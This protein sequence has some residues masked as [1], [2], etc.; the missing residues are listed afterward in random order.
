MHRAVRRP[1]KVFYQ[2]LVLLSEQ[3]E[4]QKRAHA[5]RKKARV[6]PG[7]RKERKR[8]AQVALQTVHD[9]DT[10]RKILYRLFLA[11]PAAIETAIEIYDKPR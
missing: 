6:P 9:C 4:A 3:S 5:R 7:V 10:C 1:D 11:K 8:A 2:P